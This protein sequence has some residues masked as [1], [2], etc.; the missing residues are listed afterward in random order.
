MTPAL[1]SQ[2]FS[3]DLVRELLDMN[4]DFIR[5]ER[6]KPPRGAH[7]RPAIDPKIAVIA[8]VQGM[9]V[10]VVNRPRGRPGSETVWSTET[11]VAE[12]NPIW[13]TLQDKVTGAKQSFPLNQVD[14][15]FDHDKNRLCIAID[16]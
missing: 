16:R 12:C 6:Q 10:T 2:L 13:V 14:V 7:P 11:I 1:R 4:R 9:S 3:P 5:A 8:A 15:T